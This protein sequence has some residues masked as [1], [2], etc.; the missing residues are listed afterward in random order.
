MH[1]IPDLIISTTNYSTLH[2]LYNSLIF[3]QQTFR[4]CLFQLIEAKDMVVMTMG[5]E[6]ASL[7]GI[8]RRKA[9]RNIKV[10][11]INTVSNLMISVRA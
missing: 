11:Y 9:L 4:E 6:N 7:I 3:H 10:T 1:L 5:D 8:L 2:S